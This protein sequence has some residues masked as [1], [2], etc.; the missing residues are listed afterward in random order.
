MESNLE[1]PSLE[2]GGPALDSKI[3]RL[4]KLEIL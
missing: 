3:P 2:E 1:V 4:K